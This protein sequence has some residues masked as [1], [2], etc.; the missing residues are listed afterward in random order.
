MN[1]RDCSVP[2]IS[3]ITPTY[4][5]MKTLKRAFDSLNKQ[6]FNNFEWIIGDDGSTDDTRNLI[7][8]LKEQANFEIHY[9]KFEHR[10]KAAT[11]KDIYD[12]SKGKYVIFL[13]SD[14]ELYNENTLQS[15]KN[16]I[17]NLDENE[18]FW[19]ICGCFIDQHNK[20][21]P[22]FVEEKI[23]ITKEL[24]MELLV[25]NSSL[26]NNCWIP[27]TDCFKFYNHSDIGD[28]PYYPEIV[29]FLNN[30][31]NSKDFKFILFNEPLYRYHTLNEDCVTI[32][33][34]NTPVSWYETVGII[35]LFY[36]YKAAKKYKLYIKG[37]IK[38]LANGIYKQKGIVK[39]FNALQSI[40]AK[41]KFLI[42]SQI[43]N[44]FSVTNTPD[45]K[46]K[47]ITILGAKIKIKRKEC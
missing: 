26:L 21:F 22:K 45:R 23:I 43:K 30:V 38:S 36:K 5:R 8:T 35:N 39:T 31:L 16:K 46:Y 44:I 47:Q 13:D 11:Q 12:I 3:I 42:L 27:R 4:N 34:K 15:I 9:Y 10:G 41:I 6:T 28:L 18:N 2:F 33:S 25:N 32:T 1:S 40:D 7:L 24:F 14:D 29:D 17:C 20:I 19:G 37:K